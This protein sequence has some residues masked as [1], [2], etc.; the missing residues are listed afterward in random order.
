[1]INRRRLDNWRKQQQQHMWRRRTT[2]TTA[3]QLF[4][5]IL[6]KGFDIFSWEIE[7]GITNINNKT[8]NNRRA[9]SN[10]GQYPL[11]Y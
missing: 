1:M 3:T 2:T 5:S 9:L 7:S 8:H 10:K 11:L 4:K 6:K